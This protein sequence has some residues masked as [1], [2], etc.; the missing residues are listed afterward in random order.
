MSEGGMLL[1]GLH[2]LE[3]K[4]GE[5]GATS[6]GLDQPVGVTLEPCNDVDGDAA[7]QMC[8]SGQRLLSA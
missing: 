8:M 2:R 3:A 7:L 1:L 6:A 4:S 5:D